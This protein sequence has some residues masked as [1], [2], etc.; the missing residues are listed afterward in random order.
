MQVRV[1]LDAGARTGA[2]DKEGHTPLYTAVKLHHRIVALKLVLMICPYPRRVSLIY[3]SHPG[4]WS[5]TRTLLLKKRTGK[6][7]I[8]LSRTAVRVSML[9]MAVHAALIVFFETANIEV[10]DRILKLWGVKKKPNDRDAKE[11]VRKGVHA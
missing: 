6:P 2:L 1:L 7:C 3:W 5:M 4:C 9:F 11:S 8:I 10:S